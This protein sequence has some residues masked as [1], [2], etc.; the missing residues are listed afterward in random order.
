VHI[1]A[2]SSCTFKVTLHEGSHQYIGTGPLGI[3]IEKALLDHSDAIGHR[4]PPAQWLQSPFD[5]PESGK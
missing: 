1:S 4:P 3:A 5:L 2:L